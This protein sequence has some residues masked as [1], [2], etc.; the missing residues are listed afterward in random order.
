MNRL[1]T[2]VTLL[3][4]MFVFQNCAQSVSTGTSDQGLALKAGQLTTVQTSEDANA[5][6]VQ[7][8]TPGAE[9]PTVDTSTDTEQPTVG[10]EPPTTGT[11]SPPV[12]G[13]DPSTA[14]DHGS[15]HSNGH[16]TQDAS[17]DSAGTYVCILAGPGK[18]VKLGMTS[19]SVLQGQNPVPG[20]LCM[21]ANAC[22]NIASQGFSVKGPEFR[23]YCKPH[24][25]PHVTQI[26]DAALLVKIQAL[27][28]APAPAPAQ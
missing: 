9:I 23:G 11:E 16:A 19:G 17:N 15:D 13:T 2:I 3:S 18:S 25:N 20:V 10:S 5:N 6:L 27:V 24:G 21:S 22:L 1:F 4:M 26:S 12:V 8:G 14:K 28:A 7:P